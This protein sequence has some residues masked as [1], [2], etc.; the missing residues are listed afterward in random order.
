MELDLTKSQNSESE[1]EQTPYSFPQDIKS[2][3]TMLLVVIDQI[4]SDFKQARE[5]I[6][7]IAKRLDEEEVCERNEISRTLKKILRDKIQNGKVTEKWIEECLPPEYKRTYVKS[8]L[9]SLS[10]QKN[11]QV[12][13]AP[14]GKQTPLG[15]QDDEGWLTR[16]HPS[17]K[18]ESDDKLMQKQA[19]ELEALSKENE[20]LKEVVRRQTTM[21]SADHVSQSEL[22][23]IVT[24]A[25]YD[26]LRHAMNESDNLIYLIFDKSG[27]FMHTKPDIFDSR[28]DGSL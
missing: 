13:A 4:D 9:S 21:H 23:F 14:G 19:S 16:E 27:T 22:E 10:K 25:R 28:S 5:L 8:E 7:E 18:T 15:E 24:K 11:R 20:E 26:D 12:V 3:I 2:K 17:N 6:L 1:E